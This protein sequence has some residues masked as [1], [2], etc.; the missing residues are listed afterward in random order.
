MVKTKDK[1][2]FL[3][4]QA[5]LKNIAEQTKVNPWETKAEQKARIDRAKKDVRFFV[6]EYLPH[7][8]DSESADFQTNTANRVKRNTRIFELERWGRGLAKS[9]W[10]DLVIPLWLYINDEDNYL[11]LVGNTYDKAKILLSDLQAE[12]E[13]ND[14]LIHDF[15]SQVTFGDWQD[16]D[17][18]TKDQKLTAKALGMGQS[19]RGLRKKSKRPTLVVCDDL[20]DKDTIKNPK[21][22][23]EVVTWIEQDLIPTMDNKQRRYLHPNNNFAP[24]TIQGE[25]EKRHPNWKVNRVNAYDPVTYKPTWHQKYADDHYKLLEQEIGHLAA[26]AEFNNTPHVEGKVFR[27]AW[28]QWAPVP[29]I[30]HYQHLVGY[31]DVAYSDRDTA[32]YNAIK[33]WGLK[34]LNFYQIKAFV[35]QC[36]M[37]DAIDWM[38][39]Y[40]QQLPRAVHLN[41]YYE[42]QF[43]N[44]ALQMVYEEVSRKHRRHIS[45]IKDER[46][47][48]KKYDRIVGMV[49]YY[50][51]GRI[52]YNEKEKGSNDMQTGLAQLKSIEPGY[53]THDDSP[54][55]DEGAIYLLNQHITSSAPITIGGRR[56]N[57][58]KY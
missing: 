18:T 23:D 29:R 12:F 14:L 52:Y 45:L 27:D 33:I 44:D 19:P 24:R 26:M 4:Y 32:D 7:Y 53:R 6:S 54:D 55:A 10:C 1:K 56:R 15:E 2:A 13:A 11:V 38:F 43:W 39:W 57:A 28:I 9:V 5:K 37:F 58:R 50:Q 48:P 40:A 34:D 31:W 30:D 3:D 8:A 16:G 47:K 20:E 25:L 17:F 49:P 21:R 46:K 35:Q 41:F 51:Q 36:K 22:Q 42:S